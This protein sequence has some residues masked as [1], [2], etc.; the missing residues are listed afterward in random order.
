MRRVLAVLLGLRGLMNLG[1]VP[2]G[3]GTGIVLG[4]TLFTE[5]TPLVAGSIGLGL[6][7]LLWAWGLWRA[8]GWAVPMGV[9]YVALVVV[10]IVRFPTIPGQLRENIPMAA[11]VAYGIVAIAVPALATWLARRDRAR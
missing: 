5:G 2:L 6:Y 10:N 1:K 9:A 7:M 4:G 11:Y 8:A 3:T